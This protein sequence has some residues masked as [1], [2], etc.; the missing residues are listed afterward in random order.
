M[1]LQY[2]NI[3]TYI[4]A[5]IVSASLF[6][7]SEDTMDGINKDVDN[8]HSVDAKYILTDV[9]TSTA[10]SN[11]GGSNDFYFASNVE[12]E[13][14][15]FNQ[16]YNYEMRSGETFASSTFNNQW[17]GLYST[18]MNAR[19]IVDKCS[20]NGSEAGNYTTKGMGEVL[21]ALNA[22]LIADAWGD[23]PYS[24]AALAQLNNGR[25]LY[26]NPAIDKQEDIYKDIIA[27]LDA[28]IADLPKGDKS[29]PAAQDILF[30]GNA[31]K[32]L[33]LA[34]GLKARYTMHTLNRA[35]DKTAALNAV[36][37]YCG[38]AAQ[39]TA[40]QAAFGTGIY[41]GNTNLN[42]LFD[43]FYSREYFG[44]S[45]SLAQKLV[46]MNDPRQY[47]TFVS[48]LDDANDFT[49]TAGTQLDLTQTYKKDENSDAVSPIDKMAPNGGSELVQAQE[50]YNTSIFLYASTAPTFL[51][52]YHEV[53]FLE[54]EAYAR[55]G[56][57]DKAWEALQAAITAGLENVN[58]SIE[59][60]IAT[61]FIAAGS[62]ST[63]T[64]EDIA[65][66]LP[67]VKARFDADALKEVILQK[68]LAFWGANGE[69]TECYNDVRRLKG[70]G[71][72]DYYALENPAN[73]KNLFPLRAPYGNSAVTSNPNVQSAYGDGKYIF[74]EPVWWAGGSR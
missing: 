7:C 16:L 65:A 29:G 22:G 41:D 1:K 26:M 31:D 54:A 64:A 58:V 21:A 53:K 13:V 9:I 24:Q 6:S 48:A 39:S 42:P 20:D 35:S 23:T 2:K 33:K 30:K 36:I 40:D 57:A 47:C 4:A 17:N 66:Y 73:A 11:I 67:I 44:G 74:T 63:I 72:F 45:H 34:Y 14:G 37:E 51:M 8:P 55:L 43:F 15:V 60:A 68:Y 46:D 25:P 38:K 49:G 28:A 19:I 52:S 5:A 18:L 61:G 32:W 3:Q 12:H 71:H 59:S 56:D 62:H 27:Q 10:F 69:S 70:E 50:Y